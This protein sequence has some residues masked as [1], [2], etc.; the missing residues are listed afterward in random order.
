M[1]S[2]S[3][4]LSDISR[5][6]LRVRRRALR[7]WWSA[8]RATGR[9]PDLGIDDLLRYVLHLSNAEAR[10]IGQEIVYQEMVASVEWSAVLRRSPQ[11]FASDLETVSFPDPEVI[12][13]AA[14]GGNPVIFTPIHMGCFLLPLARIMLDHFSDRRMLIFRAKEDNE[15]QTRAMQR[16]LDLG[17]EMRFLN[18]NEKQKYLDA[19]RFAKDG[20]VIVSFADLP[21]SYGAP[22][23][24]TLFGRPIQLAMGIAGLARL[25][26]ATVIP[27]AVRSSVDGDIVQL[28]QPFQTYQKNP[29]EKL[30]VASIMR[31]H[32]EDSIRDAPEQ[33]HMWP[34]FHEFLD[35]ETLQEA[36]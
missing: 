10:R 19:I 21:A 13:H 24:V 20:A 33:W 26:E 9:L 27:M 18:V 34:R 25:T 8:A 2:A 28:G 35:L 12:E 5:L 32:I 11:G 4:M 6:P 14:R 3:E 31:R 16:L 30:R 15:Q 36:V 29:A 7:L 17:I 23:P 22:A 1:I